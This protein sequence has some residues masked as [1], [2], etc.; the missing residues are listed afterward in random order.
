M[1]CPLAEPIASER[2]FLEPLTVE[3]APEMVPVLSDV[4]M[5]AFTGGEPPT[6]DTLRHRYARQAV[7]HSPDRKQGWLN[8][9]VRERATGNAVGIVQATVE[10]QADALTADLAWV[11]D[12]RAQRQGFATEAAST[13]V[14]H[15]RSHGVARF[16]AF[17]HPEHA[18]SAAV[19]A[20][21]GMTATYCVEDGETRWET[22]FA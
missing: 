4:Q 18:A 1:T 21:I 14:Q 13:I 9:V 8:W 11:I 20:R 16:A 19:A 22:T 3:H 2:L 6:L 7:G 12:P 5:Y 10:R 17:I 15:L